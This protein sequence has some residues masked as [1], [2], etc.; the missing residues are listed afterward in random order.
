MLKKMKKQ[1]KLKCWNFNFYQCWN[2]LK[3]WNYNDGMDWSM[4][5]MHKFSF[6]LGEVPMLVSYLYSAMPTI[7][8]SPWKNAHS[9]VMNSRFVLLW[10]S[11]Y[12]NLQGSYTFLSLSCVKLLS[13]NVS[14]INATT[15]NLSLFAL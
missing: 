10:S 9:F 6:I 4:W 15:V 3:C 11:Q 1:M 2:R 14:K 8:S 13:K 12:P 5:F 7:C